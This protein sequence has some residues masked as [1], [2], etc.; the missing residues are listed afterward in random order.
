MRSGIRLRGGFEPPLIY[1]HRSKAGSAVR[2]LNQSFNPT[3]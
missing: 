3:G 1:I 2:T